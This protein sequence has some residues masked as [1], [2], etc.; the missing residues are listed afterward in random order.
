MEITE[1]S[2][3]LFAAAVEVGKPYKPK[4]GEMR[5]VVGIF[6]LVLAMLVAL[7]TVA[8]TTEILFAPD[9]V[10]G[11]GSADGGTPVAL[12]V[13][14]SG[15]SPNATYHI[16]SYITKSTSGARTWNP[17][18]NQWISSGS[19]YSQQRPIQ[20]DGSG[21]WQGWIHSYYYASTQ[22]SGR[23]LKVRV[24]PDGSTNYDAVKE[25]VTVLDMS[26]TGDGCWVYATASASTQGQVV[27]AYD[28]AGTV[29]GS[30]VIE[31]N[32]V[33]EGYP[34]NPGYFKM[35]VP[36][37][38]TITKLETRDAANQVVDEQNGN[39]SAGSA[40]GETDLDA[41]GDVSLPVELL[42]FRTIE[43][44]EQRVVLEW[45]TASESEILGFRI[46]R[47]VGEESGW[48]V[49]SG[50]I[51]ARG[52]GSQGASYR[53][54]DLA[55]PKEVGQVRYALTVRNVDGTSETLATVGVKL[56]E[57]AEGQLQPN[58]FSLSPAYPNPF[59]A[60]L[61]LS[62]TRA[63][64][65]GDTCDGALVVNML[66][67][68]VARLP[69]R[70]DGLVEWDGRDHSGGTVPTGTYFIR[71]DRGSQS[72]TRRITFVR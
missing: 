20:T 33:D 3:C 41:Q 1:R 2:I 72:F 42:Y 38:T 18:T 45:R 59:G 71:I 24:T 48:E 32:Q 22:G 37:N 49:R 67:Q 36:A 43:T 26:D 35:A 50:L 21:Q 8:Q 70:K 53:W 46:A 7:S 60:A 30:W 5:G 55:L 11:D 12:F 44:S 15:G 4:E 34:A 9:Y 61:G 69:V 6:T 13:R 10:A 58:E 14:F 52:S 28:A 68:V 56:Q 66:G 62:T 64:W 23:T 63:A 54:E 19:S 40:G 27:A 51:A 31:D 65:K 29:L 39:W 16:K 17:E 47:S 25:G 57:S